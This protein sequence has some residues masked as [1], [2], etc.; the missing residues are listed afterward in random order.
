MYFINL[1]NFLPISDLN[2]DSRFQR[3]CFSCKLVNFVVKAAKY[4]NN[5][6]ADVGT[7]LIYLKDYSVYLYLTLS[8]IQM[9]LNVVYA[10][11]EI[12]AYNMLELKQS[13]A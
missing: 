7:G 2:G 4:E 6:L 8:D 10:I 12:C 3:F 9:Q 5:I 11:F 13:V 1:K